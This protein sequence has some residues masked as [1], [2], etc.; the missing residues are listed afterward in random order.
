MANGEVSDVDK[1]LQKSL[2]LGTATRVSSSLAS[3]LVRKENFELETR[4]PVLCSPDHSPSSHVYLILQLIELPCRHLSH[5]LITASMFERGLSFE[6][7][8]VPMQR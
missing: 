6:G 1:P 4:W 2:R 8:I 5:S 3:V 7:G